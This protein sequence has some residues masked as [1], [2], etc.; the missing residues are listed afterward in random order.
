M[1]QR[2]HG[3]HAGRARRAL[4]AAA[5]LG[6]LAGCASF[7]SSHEKRADA[8][9]QPTVGSQAH[10]AVT[11]VERP[12]GV[13]VTY[14]LVGLPPN[15]DH[16]LQV[17]ERG[18]CNAGDG[19]SAG[20][21][22]APAADRLRAGARVAGDLGNIHADANGVAAGFI[23]APDLALDGVRSALNRAALVH[24]DPSDPAFPQHG[25]GPALACGV[26]R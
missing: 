14:N 2:H 12:D 15:S 21:V 26:I 5:A 4:L 25:A 16:A 6:L 24:R 17:H 1:N 10:G 7:S 18:D 3:V 22:F 19:S 9:L 20:Q 13:Q 23:V 11:F 8:Q